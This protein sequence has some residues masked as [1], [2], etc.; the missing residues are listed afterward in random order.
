M[1]L[2]A[3][4]EFAKPAAIL[5]LNVCILDDDRETV[6]MLEQ[7]VKQLGFIPFGTSDPEEALEQIGRCRC[8]VVLCDLK[9]PRVDG[10][11]FLEHAV[12]RDPGI[13]FILMTGF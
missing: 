8:R 5:P 9:M 1:N 11:T 12:Q 6:E 10:L 3:T 13:F 2:V 4:K 7:T